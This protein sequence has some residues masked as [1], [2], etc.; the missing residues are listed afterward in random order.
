MDV[1]SHRHTG[2][3]YWST[4][5]RT[6]PKLTKAQIAEE[7]RRAR[8]LKKDE[9]EREKQEQKERKDQERRDKKDQKEKEK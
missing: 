9:R 5:V 8:Q 7:K 3:R 6:N 1:F 4:N 2:I